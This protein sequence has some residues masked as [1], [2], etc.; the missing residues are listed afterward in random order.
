MSEA[1]AVRPAQPALAVFASTEGPGDAERA[2][3]MSQAGNYLSRRGVRFVF[4]GGEGAFP[5][6]FVTAARTGGAEVTIVAGDDFAAPRALAAI[7]VERIADPAA[8][9][10]RVAELADVF[11]GL[12]GTL[13]SATNLYL[14]WVRAG[15]GPG[16]KPVVLLNRNRAFEVV[17][18]LYAD[19]FSHSV[20]HADHYVQFADSV[21]DL[22]GKVHWLLN[23]TRNRQRR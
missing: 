7:P 8:Q 1:P 2:S 15:A 13:A 23:E 16:G 18:G 14:S 22:W 6:P 21:E 4:L 12:P 3:L 9:L 5:T 19:V 20:R 11:V 17:R 10:V